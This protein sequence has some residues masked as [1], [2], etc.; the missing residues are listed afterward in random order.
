MTTESPLIER[1]F[2]CLGFTFLLFV[3]ASLL[4]KNLRALCFF[5]MRASSLTIFAS[6]LAPTKCPWSFPMTGGVFYWRFRSSRVW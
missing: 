6:K 4:A 1:A 3:G 5:R 2:C